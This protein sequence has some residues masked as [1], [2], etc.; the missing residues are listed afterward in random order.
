MQAPGRFGHQLAS[1]AVKLRELPDE[2]AFWVAALA[3]F[4]LSAAWRWA[5]R[6]D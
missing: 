4:T 3:I 6:K 5:N 2:V 1:G